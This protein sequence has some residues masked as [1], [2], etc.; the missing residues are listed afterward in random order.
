MSKPRVLWVGRTRYRLPLSPSLARKWDALSSELDLRVIATGSDASG[1]DR[2]FE[3]VKARTP[4]FYLSLPFT[5]ARALRT[6]QPAVIVAQSPYEA[7]AALVGRRL[8]R[9]PAR[10]VL[11]VHGDWR[12]ATRLYG[13]SLRR[14]LEPVSRAAARA[15]VRRADAVRTVSPFTTAL[16]RELGVEPAAM[17]TTFF[18]ASAFDTQPPAP[19]PS[20]PRVVFV[21]VLERYKNIHGLAEAWRLAAPRVPEAT[22]HV[23]GRGREREVMAALVRDL[24]SRVSWD[25]QLPADAV[26]SALDA[27]TVLV[28]PSF[29][30][31]LPRVAME[32]Y[33]RG[34]GIVGS[35][36][37]GIPDIVEDGT[38]GLLVPAGDAPALADALVRVLTDPELARRFG[39]AAYAASPRWLQPAEEYA[40]RMR[41][42]VE[43]LAR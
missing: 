3:L 11:E 38:T 13:S 24:P 9:S 1:T 6:F 30:E 19:L 27:A 39:E 31:G 33:A 20:R 37:G 21:G 2:R 8:A 15:A 7:A 26:A 40:S 14:L 23:I 29:S 17:F 32:S 22:L 28:L 36:A 10:V 18:D 25:E 34:R 4:A 41:A 16:V 42:L 43:G 12:T 5:V 35:R